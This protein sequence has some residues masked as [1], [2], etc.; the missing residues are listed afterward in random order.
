MDEL[1][2]LR[3]QIDLIDSQLISLYEK[4]LNTVKAVGEYKEKH[5]TNV[6]QKGRE[7]IVINN[8]INRLENKSYEFEVRELMN[9]ILDSSKNLQS[10]NM[11]KGEDLD[12]YKKYPFE[13]DAKKGFFGE[14]G[15]NTE[16]A[17]YDFFGDYNGVQYDSFEDIF[18][19]IR[20]GEIKYGVVPIENS[21]AGAITDVYDLLGEYDLGIIGEQWVRIKHN[22]FGTPDSTIEDIKKV[23]S[24]PQGFYQSK[25]FLDT[26]NWER[27]AY[28][29]TALSCKY[30]SEQK[31]KTKAA[32]ASDRTGAMYG[33]KLL[34]EDITSCKDNFTR[35]II[36]AAD[37]ADLPANK[38]SI[39]FSLYSKPGALYNIL[40]VL[41]KYNINMVKIESRPI[42]NN[43]LN[44]YFYVDLDGN[45]D[46][47]NMK[48]ALK[49][50]Q[51]YTTM[52]KLLG[53]YQKGEIK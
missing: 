37:I 48:K 46:D 4:R 5:K 16:Q 36:I 51:N 49:N 2:E 29:N 22:V 1:D 9:T 45:C 10:S 34:K 11:I 15:S 3:N 26:T 43:P 17:M 44:Y 23:Y 53:L 8:A 39:E 24:H 40:K 47:D 27:I 21:T 41:A 32:I 30:V 38:V 14:K 13:K 42:K 20:K 19:A 52:Y 35:F 50:I 6:L 18:K 31:D 12:R 33:L 25:D 28:H 7:E